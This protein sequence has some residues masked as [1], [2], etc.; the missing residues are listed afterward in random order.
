MQELTGIAKSLSRFRNLNTSPQR[1][2]PGSGLRQ[3]PLPMS[4]SSSKLWLTKAS[5]SPLAADRSICS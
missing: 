4:E 3:H 1:N 2:S 5:S